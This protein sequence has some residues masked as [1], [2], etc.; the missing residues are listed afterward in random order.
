MCNVFGLCSRTAELCLVDCS[1]WS[2]AALYCTNRNSN[3]EPSFHL[4]PASSEDI[5]GCDFRQTFDETLCCLRNRE[6]SLAFFPS[7]AAGTMLPRSMRTGGCDL[8]GVE[9]SA[10]PLIGY[11]PLTPD[12]STPSNQSRRGSGSDELETSQVSVFSV[13]LSL[14]QK[15]KVIRSRNISHSFFC[16]SFTPVL[17]FL[18]TQQSKVTALAEGE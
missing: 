4:V 14:E 2:S 17:V 10:V 15:Q 12:G 1:C 7:A 5:Q 9:S 6:T 13:T 8:P 16:F 3:K 18:L 11:R